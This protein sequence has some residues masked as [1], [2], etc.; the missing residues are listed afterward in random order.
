MASGYWQLEGDK[1]QRVPG[2]LQAARDNI[3]RWRAQGHTALHRLE[4]WER[5]LID[6]QAGEPGM[7]QLLKVLLSAEEDH[8]RLREFSPFPG[9]PTR[10]ERRRARELCGYRH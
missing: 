6:A 3:A 4:Q 1:L 5:L 9:I 7:R 2:L 8:E 10:E